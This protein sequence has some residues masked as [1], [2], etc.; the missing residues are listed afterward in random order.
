MFREPSINF[1][2]GSIYKFYSARS[3]NYIFKKDDMFFTITIIKNATPYVDKKCSE[4]NFSS[5]CLL[6]TDIFCEI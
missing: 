5:D 1:N 6:V 4:S 2:L 3:L